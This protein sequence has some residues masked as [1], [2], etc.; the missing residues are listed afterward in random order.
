[1]DRRS[2][3]WG[4][5]VHPPRAEQLHPPV[6]PG[7]EAD[8]PLQAETEGTTAPV[9]EP[10]AAGANQGERRNPTMSDEIMNAIDVADE[11][12]DNEELEVTLGLSGPSPTQ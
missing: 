12:L 6:H 9:D 8:P 1:M 3:R 11:E 4:D 10:V 5:R 2:A 7:E